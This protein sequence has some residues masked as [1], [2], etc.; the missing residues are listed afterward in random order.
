[1]K[2]VYEMPH[3]SIEEF[4]PNV[5]I[6]NC[7]DGNY[8]FDCLYGPNADNEKLI[9]IAMGTNCDNNCGFADY[10]GDGVVV[11]NSDAKDY[12]TTDGLS[13][14]YDRSERGH[15][16][17]NKTLDWGTQWVNFTKY[18]KVTADENR[19]FLGWLYIGKNENGYK[20]VDTSTVTG[21]SGNSFFKL[22]SRAMHLLL[23]PVYGN[24]VADFSNS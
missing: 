1:M 11:G 15:S 5:A 18:G 9:S 16:T 20:S 13:V 19:N 24:S 12:T 22:T 7:G 17:N 21:W 6:A 8:T 3:V 10:T 2:A 4:T 14:L 23:A